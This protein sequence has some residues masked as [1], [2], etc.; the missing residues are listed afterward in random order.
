MNAQDW[1]GWPNTVGKK[2]VLALAASSER[3]GVVMD[4]SDRSYFGSGSVANTAKIS[5]EFRADSVSARAN[6][7]GS[8]P[9]WMMLDTGSSVTVFDETVSKMLGIRFLGE[10]N[11]DGPGQGSAQKLAFANH[12]L[13]PCRRGPSRTIGFLRYN[14]YPCH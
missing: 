8:H 13:H 4:T 2:V 6:I 10:G 3:T 1:N 11:V 9:L 14:P 5:D 7:N 12:G